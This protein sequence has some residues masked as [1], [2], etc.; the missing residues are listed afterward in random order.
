MSDISRND[1]ARSIM[2]GRTSQ[3][4]LD[5]AKALE[6]VAAVYVMSDNDR[7]MTMEL[8]LIVA[9]MLNQHSFE[10]YAVA[11]TG[12]SGSGKSTLVNTSLDEMDEFQPVDD[13]YGNEVQFCL[14]VSTPSSCSTKDLGIAILR[15][16]GYPLAKPPNEGEIWNVVK[17]RLR[18]KMHKVL[19]LDEFQHALKKPG[20]KGAEHLANQIKLLMQDKEWPL[21]LII[22]GMPDVM[23]FVNRDEWQQMDRRTREVPLDALTGSPE[24]IENTKNMIGQLTDAAGLR[25]SAHTTDEFILRLQHGALWRFGLSIQLTK[26]SIEVALWDDGNEGTMKHEHF[27]EGYKRLSRCTRESNVFL[28]PD[29]RRI[30][31]EVSRNGSLTRTFKMAETPRL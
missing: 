29:W 16:S 22:A 23:E 15:A 27:V 4:V 30:T 1:L 6:E 19:F 8:E 12:P 18:A 21:W 10:G 2:R 17:N 3:H 14:R 25:L 28:S 13:G 7:K 26:M 24:T 31:R 9:D 20:A 11:V 5:R